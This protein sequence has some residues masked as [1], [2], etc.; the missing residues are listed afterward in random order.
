M[1]RVICNTYNHLILSTRSKYFVDLAAWSLN[2]S[3]FMTSLWY[4]MFY[5]WVIRM[6]FL[7][8]SYQILPN[9]SQVLTKCTFC[10]IL[11][12]LLKGKY[13]YQRWRVCFIERKM[14]YYILFHTPAYITKMLAS[15]RSLIG[16]NHCFPPLFGSVHENNKTLFIIA[17]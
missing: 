1:L 13:H 16:Q 6:A 17:R 2:L 10:S 12:F 5:N 3:L 4:V 15:R 14:K 8:S 11:N 9:F 7:L